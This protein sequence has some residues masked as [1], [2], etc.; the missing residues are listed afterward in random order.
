MRFD[1]A[2]LIRRSRNPR[3]SSITVRAIQPTD[4]MA[5]DLYLSVYRPVIMAWKQAVGRI[6]EAY[7]R[8]LP[9]NDAKI[10]A[11][12]IPENIPALLNDAIFDIDAILAAIEADLQRIVIAITPRLQEW[13]VRAEQ[14]HRGQWRRALLTATRIDA[15]T[16][17]TA[18]DVEDTVGAFVSRNVALVRS[19]SDEARQ[20]ISDIV[21]RGYQAR[22]PLRQVAREMDDAVELGRQR[23]LRISGD[24]NTKLSGAL[25]RARQQQAGIT[26]FAYHHGAPL[27]PRKWHAA[28]NGKIYDWD[29]LHQV[30]GPD[31]IDPTDAPSVPPFCTCRTRAVIDLS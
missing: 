15:Q 6:G 2:H 30:D 17:L 11:T 4:A 16:L 29:T 8:A 10:P 31:Q 21:L 18:G 24:Q 20:R 27:H 14:W 9:V 22:I 26:Q 23:A 28:R 25:D 12:N 19:V 5:S 13:S 1:I 3:R 7:G